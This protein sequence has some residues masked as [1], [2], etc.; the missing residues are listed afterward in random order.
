MND[1]PFLA[2]LVAAGLGWTEGTMEAVMAAYPYPEESPIA[3]RSWVATVA[4]SAARWPE[5]P[6]TCAER[7][8]DYARAWAERYQTD[9]PNP[10]TIELTMKENR[11]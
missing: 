8:A 5:D 6:R 9:L 7:L 3:M 11:P 2:D 4:G 10:L 1:T